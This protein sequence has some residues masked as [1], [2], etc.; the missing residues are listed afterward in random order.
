MSVCVYVCVCT[1]VRTY[2]LQCY[3]THFPITPV[4]TPRYYADAF[5]EE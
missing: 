5:G 4:S 2:A 1:Y 3:H